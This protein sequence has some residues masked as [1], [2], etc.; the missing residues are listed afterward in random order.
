MTTEAATSSFQKTV[1]LHDWWL[2][3]AEQEFQGNKIAVAGL[4][5]PEKKPVRVFHSAAISK[6][7]DVFTLQTADGVNV[8]LQGYINRKLTVENGFSSQVFRHFCFGFP[9]DWEECG[10]KFLN[11]NC[12][13]VAEPPVS[14][15]ECRPIF[16]S[17]PVDDGVN[18]LKNDDSE[19]L[20]PLSSCRVN[21]V[22][23]VKDSVVVSAKP[24]GHHVDVAL[25]SEKIGSKKSKTR[26]F[27]KLMAKS[28][29]SLEIISTKNDASGECSALTDYN[30]GNITKSNFDQTRSV[31]TSGVVLAVSLELISSLKKEKRENE[32]NKDGL[33]SGSD[34]SSPS[35]PQGPQVM[36]RCIENNTT[37]GPSLSRSPIRG[38][39]DI[40]NQSEKCLVENSVFSS[41][42]SG[43]EANI[44][45]PSKEETETLDANLIDSG[46]RKSTASVTNLT[47]IPIQKSVSGHSVR[48]K[49]KRLISIEGKP[50]RNSGTTLD[51]AQAMLR[52]SRKMNTL[53]G[54]S[55]SK[56]KKET[57]AVEKGGL[58]MKQARRKVIFDADIREMTTCIHSPESLNLK[59]SRSG[60]L[61]L[62]TLDFWRNQIPVYD[63]NRNITG[64]QEELGVVEPSR[65]VESKTQ[66]SKRE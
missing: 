51:I 60:R 14:Q 31:R 32:G 64:V 18:N 27:G 63:E 40:L 39:S 62:P 65:G 59:R 38:D 26:S 13:S 4:T 7:Y 34:F 28:S 50:K 56:E 24:S 2:I 66:K 1:L 42:R 36:L 12:E 16:L 52:A 41:M 45:S 19:N 57:I 11:S 23:W 25:S 22:S 21:D 48:Y 3:K 30:V 55:K 8:L 61:L 49:A 47:N 29:S 37:Q 53:S 5:S 43:A 54:N 35:L 9:P 44:I 15:N 6:R 17:L 10:T 58:S 33:K 20:S 46:Q